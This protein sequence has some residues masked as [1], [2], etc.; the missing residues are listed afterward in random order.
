MSVLP[1]VLES[2]LHA[3]FCGT[4]AGKKSGLM[5]HYYAGP[6][7]R[8]WSVLRQTGLTESLLEPAHFRL[9]LRSRLGLTDL[10]KTTSGSD[11]VIQA[12]DFDVESFRAKIREYRPGV[13]AFNGKKAALVALNRNEINFG[14]QRGVDLHGA[15][16]WVLPSTSGAANGSWDPIYWQ[17]LAEAVRALRPHSRGAPS[18]MPSL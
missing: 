3:A 12:G 9:I 15:A 17:A 18:A 13:V 14:P 8:F 16:V 1:D 10:S 5:G 11:K 6:G 2:G 7:N 4:G